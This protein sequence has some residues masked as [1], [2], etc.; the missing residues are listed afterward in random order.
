MPEFMN[1]A[2][3]D[4]LIESWRLY[5]Q[6]SE[7]LNDY[8]ETF[9]LDTYGRYEKYGNTTIMTPSQRDMLDKVYTKLSE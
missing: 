3:I 8:E 5:K 7:I 9:L 2:D 4:L 1:S 6:D